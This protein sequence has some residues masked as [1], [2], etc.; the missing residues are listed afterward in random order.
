MLLNDE[1]GQ[2]IHRLYKTIERVLNS[3]QKNHDL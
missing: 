2:Y 1:K 3:L